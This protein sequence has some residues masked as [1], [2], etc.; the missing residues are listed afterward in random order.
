MQG[1]IACSTFAL[2]VTLAVGRP[3]I[4]ARTHISPAGAAIAGTAC[5]LLFGTVAPSDIAFAVDTL[6]RPL[7]GIL[8]I[9]VTTAAARRVGLIDV[10]AHAV[11]AGEGRPVRELF[12]RVFLLSLATASLLSN[13]AAVLV[14]TPLVLSFVRGRYPDHPSLLLPFAFAVFMAAGVAPFVISNPMNMVVASYA[15]LDFN[16]YAATML[17]IAAAGSCVTFLL[18]RRVFAAELSLP[19]AA[20]A[21]PA[22]GPFTRGQ[23]RMLAL[24]GAVTV[25]YPLFGAV[26]G[27]AIWPVAAAGAALAVLVAWHGERVAPVQLLRSVSWD[28]LIFLPAVFVLSL[29]LR[30]VGLVDLLS[31]WYVGAGPGVIGVTSAI[32]SAALN[33]HPMALVNMLA[34]DARPGAGPPEFLAALVGGDLGPRLLPTGSLAG[35]LWF[36][37]CR[38]LGV[39]ISPG[40]FVRVGVLLTLPTLAACLAMLALMAL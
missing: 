9:M 27:A 8:S 28:V 21:A 5:L 35:L 39:R 4:G 23:G 3:R 19:V 6:W 11:L 29:G 17:P 2:A 14:L 10:V 1:L 36:E 16:Q 32:G 25:S 26:E 37:S 20:A 7:L 13:D 31:A 15:D 18:L 34:L 12:G 33:N 24:L 40:L 38:R 22:R 30:N